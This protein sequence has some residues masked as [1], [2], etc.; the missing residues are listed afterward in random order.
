MSNLK[1]FV[2][3]LSKTISL[4]G[5]SLI[6]IGH[7]TNG[8]KTE[9]T[10]YFSKNKLAL[11][12]LAEQFI[13]DLSEIPELNHIDS[14]AGYSPKNIT[15]PESLIYRYADKLNS[16]EIQHIGRGYTQS[17]VIGEVVEIV[18]YS[19]EF[20][21]YFIQYGFAYIES[22]DPTIRGVYLPVRPGIEYQ[23]QDHHWSAFIRKE[24]YI[25]Y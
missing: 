14:D 20:D 16:L 24:N 7:E 23:W 18:L 8:Y 15:L 5:S 1:I 10:E 12:E 19:E 6:S 3:L 22:P 9:L 21:D 2:L 25:L 4:L 13:T 17:S 11:Y